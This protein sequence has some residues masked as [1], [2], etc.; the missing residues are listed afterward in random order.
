MN[1]GI[2]VV[3]VITLI[4]AQMIT[5]Y[6]QDSYAQGV[7]G[8]PVPGIRVSPSAE[9][10]PPVLKGMKVD[11]RRPF[12]FD[13]ILDSGNADLVPSV[14]QEEAG[15]LIRYF[16]TSLTIPEE[17]LWVN[18]SPY[19]KN[20]IIPQE[21]DRTEMGRDLLAQDYLLK[22]LA[23]SLIYP[24]EE[25][26]KE[27]WEKVYARAQDLYG[28]SEI[29]V[30]TFNKVWIV[31]KE[32]VIYEK[33]DI[34]FILR[35]H[36]KVM[37]EEDYLA[38][39]NNV[40]KQ[41][42]K[43]LSG[44]SAEMIREVVIPE[45]EK[46][47]NS[48][49][50][51]AKLRQVYHSL[52]LAKWYKERLQE[53]LLNQVYSDQKKV[54]G[55][56]L[57]DK[58]IKE[59]IY[60]QYLE[61]FKTE[62]FSYIKEDYDAISQEIVH[63]KY[64]AG[65]LGLMR[66]PLDVRTSLTPE[67][68]TQADT[69]M[70]LS[71]ITGIYHQPRV[72]PESV[73]AFIKKQF[74][75]E[76]VREGK[77]IVLEDGTL[78]K[79]YYV[80]DLLL[81]AGQLGHIG[82]VEKD[83]NGR[84]IEGGLEVVFFDER[85]A[86]EEV[87]RNHEAFKVS[88][89]VKKRQFLGRSSQK[90]REWVKANLTE[91]IEF[92][93]ELDG[94]AEERFPLEPFYAEAE[95]RGEMPSNEQIAATYK[96]RESFEDLNLAAG[97]TVVKEELGDIP[98]YI[99]QETAIA[100]KTFFDFMKK[101]ESPNPKVRESGINALG[102]LIEEGIVAQEDITEI[103][104]IEKL[105]NVHF[106]DQADSI[107]AAATRVLGYFLGKGW[108]SEDEILIKLLNALEDKSGNV[109]TASAQ[110]LSHA[111][112]R[113]FYISDKGIDGLMKIAVDSDNTVNEIVAQAF[114]QALEKDVYVQTILEKLLETMENLNSNQRVFVIKVL[115]YALKQGVHIGSKGVD[116]LM[117]S[118]SDSS[119]AVCIESMET[120][121]YLLGE[122]IERE[123]EIVIKIL[124]ALEKSNV[125]F[126]IAAL[127]AIGYG[128]EKGFNTGRKPI[129]ALL[130]ALR[131]QN[132][133]V[134]TAAA[135]ALAFALARD[136]DRKRIFMEL[137]S[138][139]RDFYFNV[140]AVETLGYAWEKNVDIGSKGKE[141]LISN[142][143]NPDLY[144]LPVV[145]TALGYGLKKN[146]D[147]GNQGISEL[148]NAH[149]RYQ[150]LS[151]LSVLGYSLG[152]GF[153]NENEVL[154][155]ILTQLSDLSFRS[156]EAAV[157]ALGYALEND[158][159]IGNEGI[160]GLL[161]A[162]GDSKDEVHSAAAKVLV[163]TLGK[164]FDL[165]NRVLV[166][167]LN[168][169]SEL[170]DDIQEAFVRQLAQMIKK[171]KRQ[172]LSM[173]E[174]F[175][176]YT[177]VKKEKES[178]AGGLRLDSIYS[179]RALILK[180]YS[181]IK[182]KIDVGDAEYIEEMIDIE[183]NIGDLRIMLEIIRDWAEDG[184]SWAQIFL[185]RKINQIV[186]LGSLS[187]AQDYIEITKKD[188]LLIDVVLKSSQRQS[189]LP[190]FLDHRFSLSIR[191]KV[192][193]ALA[194]NGHIDLAY[195]KVKKKE[196][197]IFL[198]IVSDVYEQTGYIVPRNVVEQ[199]IRKELDITQITDEYSSIIA[200]KELEEYRFGRKNITLSEIQFGEAGEAKNN[201]PDFMRDVFDNLPT[202]SYERPKGLPQ[203]AFIQTKDIPVYTIE[204][205]RLSGYSIQERTMTLGK[206]DLQYGRTRA[207]Y[208]GTKALHLKRLKRGE[209][210]QLL[211]YE[212]DFMGFFNSKKE[213]WRLKG[214]YPTG[215]IPLGYL[216]VEDLPQAY[217]QEH[218][219][220]LQ[221]KGD[222]IVLDTSRGYYSFMDYEVDLRGSG[223]NSFATYLN[224]P[225]LTHEEFF[226][227]LRINVHD[228]FVFARHDLFD[229][230]MIEL[231]H[232]H[233]NRRYD[234]MINVRHQEQTGRDGAGRM[235]DIV[236]ATR[237]PNPRVS[238]PSDYAGIIF[239]NDLLKNRALRG[240]ADDRISTLI[241]MCGRNELAAQNYIRAALL[242]DIFLSF[243]L[244]ITS[245]LDRRGELN[246]EVETADSVEDTVLGKS[247]KILFQ[248]AFRA[249]TG[250]SELPIELETLDFMLMKKQMAYFLTDRYVYDLNKGFQ[251][252]IFSGPSDIFPNTKV[253]FSLRGE[254][255]SFDPEHGW[256][257]IRT[258]HE[259][260]SRNPNLRIIK[261][262]RDLGSFNGVN[263]LQEFIKSLYIA[264]TM[265]TVGRYESLMRSINKESDT[266]DANKT[267]TKS[268]FSGLYSKSN[269][270]EALLSERT[271]GIDFNPNLLELQIQG[272]GL[273]FNLPLE[274]ATVPQI[275]IDGLFPV[276][277]NITPIT[278]LPV[279]LGV[280]TAIFL[281]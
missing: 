8:L 224:D 274:E 221:G 127:K 130:A 232:T 28:P 239:L 79:T 181:I 196:A 271:G 260:P 67:Q 119:E 193:R 213:E 178:G 183:E 24:E 105:M 91:A 192:M 135:Q 161:Y 177:L 6:P 51:F 82:F 208:Q 38:L 5:L 34:A 52:I 233:G 216:E 261:R 227:A 36:L 46:E 85:Y 4:A 176:Y 29:P 189:L 281:N 225:D 175:Y 219:T 75:E 215:V 107:R 126:R 166:E 95:K 170:E 187:N 202:L 44:V 220:P 25:L 200:K 171:R 264:T 21:F 113:G 155:E 263:P 147:V 226:E 223:M 265:M 165:E 117:D 278:N 149:R 235:N 276:I 118:F 61:A 257:I 191:Y 230:E 45:I 182:G 17:D 92:L 275:Q 258:E 12:A 259:I 109:R 48:G 18:L 14:L 57:R 10:I 102:I 206:P 69:E 195:Y 210:P 205:K 154:T 55:V 194:E 64:F 156:R 89:W 234:W 145:T 266:W 77:P 250:Y 134:R 23:S 27:F 159:D 190:I 22:Q 245:Y 60:Q 115:K 173:K 144:L 98:V 125:K 231:F 169:F 93:H 94:K 180:I 211:K 203:K 209:N 30:N 262:S 121:G 240:Q 50:N 280:S 140:G 3:M 150:V 268:S 86:E 81:E 114:A 123:D 273:D 111:L 37:L 108:K 137:I 214:Q 148:L 164:G 53:S 222:S 15:K 11:L 199:I 139:G 88:R 35:S 141:K 157:Q 277:T 73:N 269:T 104:F 279:I 138:Q 90:M 158:F 241:D 78:R 42:M 39:N 101:L 84:A 16:L 163:Q 83:E 96:R 13:F 70:K 26:G 41:E 128:L 186:S 168:T 251:S 9:F 33:K 2:C 7:L 254:G 129:D 204:E 188:K 87:L 212:Y 103:M 201:F 270:D 256:D 238:G 243:K 58:N 253:N 197:E 184:L 252:G 151:A 62:V 76:N 122:D 217:M 167:L 179:R 66:V 136:I 132:E 174:V 172:S 59:K 272:E 80:N 146:F 56:D 20:R 267:A 133:E 71:W 47:I 106:L 100:F 110:A 160:V 1:K 248:E 116:V 68:L 246:Y 54:K 63:R 198:T 228:Q 99:L 236:G 32:A 152:K 207:Y 124:S 185:Q 40:K 242:G 112:G 65:G 229:I 31:P 143:E 131:D 218:L 153:E 19:E 74:R 249:Y 255:Q 142:L 237:Y 97:R 120:L 43:K 49:K 72:S 162:L 244:L 247:L